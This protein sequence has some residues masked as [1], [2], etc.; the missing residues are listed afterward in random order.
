MEFQLED[1]EGEFKFNLLEEKVPCYAFPQGFTPKNASIGLV[2]SLGQQQLLI[3]DLKYVLIGQ[4]GCYIRHS[5]SGGYIINSDVDIKFK[6]S[7]EVITKLA[8]HFKQIRDFILEF[9][10]IKFGKTMGC[11]CYHL[12]CFLNH[13]TSMVSTIGGDINLFSLIEGLEMY[14][15]QFSQLNMIC[16]TIQQEEKKRSQPGRYNDIQFDHL[17]NSLKQDSN[18]LLPDSTPLSNVKGGIILNIIDNQL[19]NC[20]GDFKMEEFVSSIYENVSK[21]FISMLNKWLNYGEIEDPFDEFG[22]VARDDTNFTF[23]S[24]GLI[25]HDYNIQR[26]ILLTGKFKS[27][28]KYTNTAAATDFKPFITSLRS[29]DITLNLN[30][31]Y[32]EANQIL[33]QS[34]RD[35]YNINKLIPEIINWY[36][37]R[38]PLNKQFN[39]I[40][41]GLKKS[42]I[43]EDTLIKLK[44]CYFSNSFT[45]GLVSFKVD[46][47]SIIDELQ[48]LIDIKAMDAN[49]VLKSQSMGALTSMF[50]SFN[51]SQTIEPM[52]VGNISNLKLSIDLPSPLNEIITDSQ[53]YELGLIFKF[54]TLLSFLEKRFD[55]SWREIGYS[56][57]WTWGYDNLRILKL[58]KIGRLI[59]VKFFEFLR[60]YIHYM[61]F[62]VIE[63]NIDLQDDITDL[64]E[65][66]LKLNTFLSSTLNDCLLTDKIVSTLIFSMLQ[67]LLN[68]NEYIFQLRKSFV[69][70]DQIK[71]S[72]NVESPEWIEDKIKSI[73]DRFELYSNLFESGL[74]QLIDE[75]GEMG[76][77]DNG[78]VL[79]LRENLDLTFNNH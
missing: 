68:F 36:L 65:F 41:M 47:V 13:Y 48:K 69:K 51:D 66:K 27:I 9:N 35:K 7:I 55:K 32:Q 17:I 12:D 18:E 3:R 2:S 29:K 4:E 34:L 6:Q 44:Q 43:N 42:N 14:I 78:K 58:I 25:F 75:L 5:R 23:K 45:Y 53:Q 46:D 22:I 37:I 59:H 33:C 54:L 77:L 20:I 50:K 21:P 76:A 64:E 26:L 28:S 38:G 67:L 10:D 11:L 79:F 72:V 61:K 49:E 73:N 31:A 57:Y 24:D 16:S 71:L 62:S 56:I 39:E 60:I 8:K 52:N 30:I 70:M 40:L 19:R 74:N 15:T 63:S 1:S